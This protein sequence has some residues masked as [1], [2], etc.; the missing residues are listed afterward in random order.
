MYGDANDKNCLVTGVS[1][2]NPKH[3]YST[4]ERH[5]K[6]QQYKNNTEAYFLNLN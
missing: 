3:F 1:E 5:E 4:L 2:F 6:S